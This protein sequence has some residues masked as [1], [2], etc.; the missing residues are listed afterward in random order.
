M[1]K[2]PT[3]MIGHVVSFSGVIASVIF[4]SLGRDILFWISGCMVVLLYITWVLLLFYAKH[5]FSERISDLRNSLLN[6]RTLE[7]R[8]KGNNSIDLIEQDDVDVLISGLLRETMEEIPSWAV[9]EIYQINDLKKL[10]QDSSDR[11]DPDAQP[12]WLCS[13]SI[14]FFIGCPILFVLALIMSIAK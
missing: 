5:G 9:T 1:M 7:K 12:T 4:F 6:S 10:V 13:V 11:V 3:P 14:L 2:K 8:I